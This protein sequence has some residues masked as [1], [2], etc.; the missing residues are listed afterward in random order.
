[1]LEQV[2]QRVVARC[3]GLVDAL[4]HR[5]LVRRVAHAPRKAV[6]AQLASCRPQPC[7]PRL[8]ATKFTLQSD[9]LH[10]RGV[11]TAMSGMMSME[12]LHTCAWQ[13]IALLL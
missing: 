13:G 10:T 6:H 7:G 8:Q 12:N 11:A 4:Q 1:M 9:R 2:A 3:A 5:V